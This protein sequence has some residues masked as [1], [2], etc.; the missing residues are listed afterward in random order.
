MVLATGY[1]ARK[2]SEVASPHYANDEVFLGIPILEGYVETLRFIK[3]AADDRRDQATDTSTPFHTLADLLTE[4]RLATSVRLDSVLYHEELTL[5]RV[6]ARKAA[7]PGGA[8]RSYLLGG[9]IRHNMRIFNDGFASAIDKFFLRLAAPQV[10]E[11]T[12]LPL[13]GFEA[14]VMKA[15]TDPGYW[16]A[17][18][19]EIISAAEID[20]LL[21]AQEL[22]AIQRHAAKGANV[23]RA[24]LADARQGFMSGLGW[25]DFS[26]EFL[27]W[28]GPEHAY[29]AAA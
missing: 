21:L 18:A 27:A 6:E 11:G 12:H 14:H 24:A 16:R 20:D 23:A 5:K 28:I 13:V 4:H 1:A 22:Q 25:H 17:K 19:H 26:E 29:W 7:G 3:A 10:R 8:D 15:Y 2:Q 9:R